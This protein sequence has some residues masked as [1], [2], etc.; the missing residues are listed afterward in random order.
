[1]RWTAAVMAGEREGAGDPVAQATGAPYKAFAEVAGRPMIAHVLD[2]LSDCAAVDRI[3]VSIAPEA[4]PLPRGPWERVDADSGPSLSAMAALDRAGVPLLIATADHPLLTGEIVQGFLAAAETTG[5]DV[6]AA[7]AKR[8]TVERAGSTGRR[9]YLRLADAEISGCNLFALRS[10]AARRAVLFWQRL[11]VLRKRPLQMAWR[12]GPLAL[13][14][15]ATRTLTVSAAQAALTRATGVRC[16]LAMLD[17]PDAAHDVD[18]VED[19]VFADARL[20]ARH[21]RGPTT[22]ADTRR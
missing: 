19:L 12:I 3:I 13:L 4:P 22:I 7:V 18:T 16:A 8:E 15:Y 9:T 17:A 6:V 10:A 11:E 2:A 1:M 21:G 14:R 5:A 20:R